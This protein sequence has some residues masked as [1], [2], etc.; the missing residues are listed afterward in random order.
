MLKV[1]GIHGRT[2]AIIRIP[3]GNSGKAFLECEFGRGRMG[4]GPANRPATYATA[5]PAKQMIIENSP[6]YGK[7]IKLIR[8]YEDENDNQQSQSAAAPAVA[9][10]EKEKPTE[11]PG[12]E[13]REDAI[14]YLKAHGAKA[15]NLKDDESIKKF[16]AK[17]GVVFPNF[18]F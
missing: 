6:L 14:A 7:T 16:M 1:Y 11:V 13:S 18:E 17:S 4:V 15:V 8:Y 12:V 9:P 10:A 2:T 3:A 5:D